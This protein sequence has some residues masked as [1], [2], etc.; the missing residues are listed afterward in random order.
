MRAELPSSPKYVSHTPV[1]TISGKDH[2][3]NGI[4]TPIRIVKTTAYRTL[5]VCSRMENRIRPQLFHF[6][7]LDSFQ[8]GVMLRR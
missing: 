1:K 6:N 7:P 8:D 2:N 3:N 5:S 4:A